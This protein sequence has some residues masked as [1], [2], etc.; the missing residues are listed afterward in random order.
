VLIAQS[1]ADIRDEGG[2]TRAW[3]A[4]GGGPLEVRQIDYGEV[5]R[6]RAGNENSDWENIL[7]AYLAGEQ[8]DIDDSMLSTLLE[9]ANEP[10]RWPPSSTASSNAAPGGLLAEQQPCS[11]SSSGRSPPSSRARIR[12]ARSRARNIAN[13]LPRMSPEIVMSRSTSRGR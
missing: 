10:Q 4:G 5:L 9:I 1:P 12:A 6:E 3:E 11:R 8:T 7:S 2:I 13:S